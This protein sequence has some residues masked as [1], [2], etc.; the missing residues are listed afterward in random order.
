MTA[1]PPIVPPTIAPIGVGFLAGAD[2]GGFSVV[3]TGVNTATVRV[4]V[5]EVERVLIELEVELDFGVLLTGV[6][7]IGV[8][9][10]PGPLV[11]Q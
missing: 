10:G 6:L 9:S 3:E 1:M 7:L 8:V 2:L 11:S 4:D 5:A